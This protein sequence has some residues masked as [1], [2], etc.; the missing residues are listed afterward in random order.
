MLAAV[1]TELS[2]SV[3]ILAAPALLLAFGSDTPMLAAAALYVVGSLAFGARLLASRA[4]LREVAIA[5]RPAA[6]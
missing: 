4:R 3:P 5:E 6:D 2:A 1:M